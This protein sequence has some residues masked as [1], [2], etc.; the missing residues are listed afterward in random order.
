MYGLVNRAFEQMIIKK[1][2]AENWKKIKH[3]ANVEVE[4]FISNVSYPDET[5]YKLVGTASEILKIEI[6]ELLYEFGQY[7]VLHTGTES[8]GDL[9]K[10]AGKT[11]K[12]FLVNLQDFH[13]RVQLYYPDLSPPTF[14][15]ENVN[16]TSL[17]LHYTSHRHGLTDFVLGLIDGLGKLYNTAI[18]VEILSSSEQEM[19]HDVFHIIFND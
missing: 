15:V 9:L 2:G 12:E 13:S 4:V 7:W 14:F 11:L 6:K 1:Y 8:Y 5:T 16:E 10:S 18:T 17:D 3:T 19:T